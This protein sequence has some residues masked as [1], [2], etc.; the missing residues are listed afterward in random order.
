MKAPRKT[1]K[2]PIF[3]SNETYDMERKEEKTEQKDIIFFK[4]ENKNGSIDTFE[5]QAIQFDIQESF[6]SNEPSNILIDEEATKFFESF[7]EKID[8][9]DPEF[10]FSFPI[11][12]YEIT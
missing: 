8:F 3:R 4:P 11:E 7:I 9:T 6:I 10:E 2:R 12:F 5:P 1:I